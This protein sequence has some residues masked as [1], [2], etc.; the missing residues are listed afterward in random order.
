MMVDCL[1]ERTH[2]KAQL[3]HIAISATIC[4]GA[5]F[6]PHWMIKNYGALAAYPLEEI[7]LV[8]GK[9]DK[10]CMR[11]VI[12]VEPRESPAELF[13]K[14][15]IDEANFEADFPIVTWEDVNRAIKGILQQCIEYE[16]G[17][18]MAP[19]PSIRN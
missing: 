4:L 12:L 6:R 15:K 9:E 1:R 8:F 13:K 7:T 19:H 3:K 10:H 14:Y 17:K 18:W 2:L 5:G 11:E 16:K